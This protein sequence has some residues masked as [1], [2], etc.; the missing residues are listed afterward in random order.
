LSAG[1]G[2][3]G[4]GFG[5]AQRS[6]WGSNTWSWGV[7]GNI[8]TAA[9]LNEPDPASGDS[10][11]VNALD[12]FYTDTSNP[13]ATI[14]GPQAA[15]DPQAMLQDY[16]GQVT[17]GLEKDGLL[18]IATG[19]APSWGKAGN[20][21]FD[22]LWQAGSMFSSGMAG[23]P[24]IASNML[25][26]TVATANVRADTLRTMEDLM[27]EAGWTRED[28]AREVNTFNVNDMGDYRPD[29]R[30]GNGDDKRKKLQTVASNNNLYQPDTGGGDTGANGELEGG[31]NEALPET[32]AAAAAEEEKRKARQ[33][34]GYWDM[35]RMMGDNVVSLFAPQAGGY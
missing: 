4:G 23:A 15:T 18:T 7:F 8:A 21:A 5:K 16:W 6:N 19:Y 31:D 14:V 20:A 10:A 12:S 25:K 29:M 24:A 11:A 13:A 30:G 2:K 3:A 34:V 28:A 33:R 26:A 32:A 1:A 9:G 22:T 35:R 27:V 17:P